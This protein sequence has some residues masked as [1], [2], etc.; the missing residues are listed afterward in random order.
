MIPAILKEY[1]KAKVL[2]N[3]KCAGILKDL[4]QIPDQRFEIIKDGDAVDI[5]GRT[6]KFLI[7]LWIHWPET[8]LTYLE[9][10]R[11]LFTC[12]L[13]GSH[14]ATSDLF[15]NDL[16]KTYLSAKRYYAEIMMPFRN[17]I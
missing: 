9:E 7:T 15:V 10:D 11:I 17:H 8:M 13:F 3:E 6:L 12:D 5:G 14:L 4:L 1:A 2:T 16:R